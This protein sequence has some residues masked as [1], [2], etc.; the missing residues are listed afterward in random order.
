M[1][2]QLG[3]DLLIG[4]PVHLRLLR[5]F[6]FGQHVF[7]R[8]VRPR[9]VAAALVRAELLRF[10]GARQATAGIGTLKLKYIPKAFPP[11]IPC[12][13][14]R[15]D[16]RAGT[17]CRRRPGQTSDIG[18]ARTSRRR[19]SVEGRKGERFLRRCRCQSVAS[20]LQGLT[21]V[22]SPVGPSGWLSHEDWGL[23]GRRV[24]ITHLRARI[25][26]CSQLCCS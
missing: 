20:H 24:A 17:E 9:L 19:Q 16:T 23:L 11:V 1:E 4:K 10:F 15:S 14:G 6:G 12:V 3:H 2:R 21:S 18:S 25:L 7:G 26:D 22:S 13:A 5:R 8:S